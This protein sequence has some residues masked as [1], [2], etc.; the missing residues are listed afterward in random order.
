MIVVHLGVTAV[1]GRGLQNE[2]PLFPVARP[3]IGTA[4]GTADRRMAKIL[5]HTNR[6]AD[7]AV[8]QDSARARVAPPGPVITPERWAGAGLS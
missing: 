4:C 7:G 5:G 3:D 2:L 8:G 1:P 6:D